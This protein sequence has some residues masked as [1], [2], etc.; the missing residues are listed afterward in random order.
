[1]T[2]WMDLQFTC[3]V[4]RS[5]A[6]FALSPPDIWGDCEQVINDNLVTLPAGNVEGRPS[7]LVPQRWISL[8]AQ[9]ILDHSKAAAS[10]GH[11]Q[12][13]PKRA[14]LIP[15]LNKCYRNNGENC[16]HIKKANEQLINDRN[17]MEVVSQMLANPL[18][19]IP[20]DEVVLQN[21]GFN[22]YS[23]TIMVLSHYTA[24]ISVPFPM[25]IQQ[26]FNNKH[27]KL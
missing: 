15:A 2:C 3:R 9:Q 5:P 6:S 22:F 25:E 1:M 4:Q 10:A 14:T 20:E 21:P 13:G 27:V 12:W 7:I 8:V 23:T 18:K 17:D 19:L 24:N 11:H 26:W 16:C